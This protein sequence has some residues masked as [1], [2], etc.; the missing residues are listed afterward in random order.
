VRR[1]D[2]KLTEKLRR[3]AEAIV[4]A[5]EFSALVDEIEKAYYVDWRQSTDVDAREDVWHEYQG[6]NRMIGAFKGLN[7]EKQLADKRTG[8][9]KR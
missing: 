7:M 3:F 1:T 5:E 8:D 4:N 9:G 2:P 6:F